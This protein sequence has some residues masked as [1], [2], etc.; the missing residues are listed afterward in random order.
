MITEAKPQLLSEAYD[1]LFANCEAKQTLLDQVA[2]L[3][4]RYDTENDV[5]SRILARAIKKI[6]EGAPS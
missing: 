2:E 4:R 5:P 1:R 3:A 6:L